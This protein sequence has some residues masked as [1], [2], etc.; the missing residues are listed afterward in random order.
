MLKINE[1]YNQDCLEGIKLIDN[2]SIDCILTD[3]PYL[4]LDHKL[5]RDFNEDTLFSEWKRVL[6]KDGFVVVFG[7]GTSFYRWNTKL[8][9]LGFKFKE[10]IIWNKRKTSSPLLNLN[11]IHE[12]ISIHTLGNGLIK[13][14]H[15]PYLEIKK[16][17]I[18]GVIM[19]IKRLKTV[20]SNVKNFEEV[21]KYL[22][23]GKKA[24]N[25]KRNDTFETT[26]K[27]NSAKGSNET[28]NTLH[29]VMNGMIEKSIIEINSE[30]LTAVH[31]TQKPD[32][33]LERLLTLTTE[34]N[35]LILDCFAGSG[36]TLTACIKSNRNFIGFEIDFGYFSVA[37]K[38]ISETQRPLF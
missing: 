31:P 12:T 35:A 1:I 18:D 10:E 20:F 15:V 22:K 11:R 4:Y 19:D 36:S 24:F 17:N 25:K 2:N 34:E 33:L 5:D 16:H 38:R 3:P 6:K 9:N 23:S 13:K 21:E 26:I 29:S 14:S 8:A 32:R 37:K 30:R 28:T 7:R 27:N